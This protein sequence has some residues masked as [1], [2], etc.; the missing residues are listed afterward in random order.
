MENIA[1]MYIASTTTANMDIK[2]M[3]YIY[4]AIATVIVGIVAAIV[5]V[6]L[7]WK[8]NKVS[9]E[10]RFI[11]T[12]STERVKWINDLRDNFSE[13]LKLVHMQAADFDRIKSLG[14]DSINRDELRNRS[15][16]IS[17]LKNRIHLYLNPTEIIT[18]KLIEHLEDIADVLCTFDINA[19]DF[20]QV[21]DLV[22]NLG[23]LQQVILKS[24]WRRVK[25]ENEKGKEIDDKRM[26]SIYLETAKKIDPSKYNKLIAKS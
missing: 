25:E 6:F 19:F 16:E 5:N 9:K 14:I 1:M 8:N 2:T 20:D 23:Y 26:D 11:D 24:E 18:K 4:G 12:I 10:K 3:V 15:I 21:D 13:F 22:Q 17:Y 7:N